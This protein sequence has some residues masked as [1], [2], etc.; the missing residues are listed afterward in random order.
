MN[1]SKIA[2]VLIGLL[3]LTVVACK[4]SEKETPNGFKFNLVKAGDGVLPIK[5][6]ILVFDYELK[7]SKD[8]V[9]HNTVTDGM[10]SA[11]MI[12]D[13]SQLKTENGIV[14]MFRM[15]SKGDSVTFRIPV[16]KFFKDVI[17]QP[18]PPQ[19]DSTLSISYS[20]NVTGIMGMEDFNKLQATMM[21]KKVAGQKTK[22]AVLINKYLADNNIKAQQDTSG[23]YYVIHT[24][25]G[26]LKPTAENCVEVNYKGVF[27]KDGQEFDK[28]SKVAFPLN[29]VIR[30]W[31]LGIPMLGIGDSATFYIPSALGYGPQGY[32]GAIP[33]DAILIFDVKLLNVGAG[34]DRATQSCN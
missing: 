29:G 11:V 12:A 25:N 3:L 14:Q 18:L 26:G 16:S 15:L 13:T 4:N 10:P 30:G 34:Y 24:S 32:P 31:T 1:M 22:D 17:G 33:P 5:D 21:E 20:M 27:M 23:L 2:N 7:D 19:I 6:Q 9:W 8:S 28:N